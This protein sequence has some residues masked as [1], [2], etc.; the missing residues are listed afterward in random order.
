MICASNV[1]II[2]TSGA[3]IVFQDGNKPF[4]QAATRHNLAAGK[5]KNFT[6]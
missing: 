5:A 3:A 6:F 2:F 4:C 1:A